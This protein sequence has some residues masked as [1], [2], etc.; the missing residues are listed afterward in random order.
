MARDD[1][2]NTSRF[3]LWVLG[4]LFSLTS[5]LG[6]RQL[7]QLERDTAT[8]KLG[9]ESLRDAF[10]RELDSIKNKQTQNSGSIDYLEKFRDHQ[11]GLEEGRSKRATDIELDI[12]SLKGECQA[13]AKDVAR[14]E[15]REEKW[16]KK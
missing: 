14:L 7:S 12:R 2:F 3:I 1:Q 4:A 9:L 16:Q 5:F 11:A 15:G 13:L 6:N 10:Y 8:I